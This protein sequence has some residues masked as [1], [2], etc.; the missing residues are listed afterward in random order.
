MKSFFT[1][2]LMLASV[3]A[4]GQADLLDGF[5]CDPDAADFMGP[6]LFA[7]AELVSDGVVCDP[8]C[9]DFDPGICR[10]KEV[11]GRKRLQLRFT[12]YLG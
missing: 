6:P 11:V 4:I 5:C 8:D 7:G 1:S 12:D 9:S 2:F 3:I 10:A